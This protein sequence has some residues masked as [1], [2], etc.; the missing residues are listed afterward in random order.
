MVCNT[1][2]NSRLSLWHFRISHISHLLHVQSNK[3]CFLSTLLLSGLC[4]AA[5]FHHLR[6]FLSLLLWRRGPPRVNHHVPSGILLLMLSF[7]FGKTFPCKLFKILIRGLPEC[8]AQVDQAAAFCRAPEGVMR[9]V[10]QTYPA[11]RCSPQLLG[12]HRVE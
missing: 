10:P 1:T 4:S 5:F 6:A 8:L 2:S 9:C 11:R 3:Y 7:L 12:R